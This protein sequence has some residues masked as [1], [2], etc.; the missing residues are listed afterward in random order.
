MQ[1]V[2]ELVKEIDQLYIALKLKYSSADSARAI[3]DILLHEGIDKDALGRAWDEWY[4]KN[5]VKS[6][7]SET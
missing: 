6:R 3:N 2:Q 5:R 4:L 1:S 7:E